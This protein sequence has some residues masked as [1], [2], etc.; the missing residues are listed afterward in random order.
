MAVTFEAL[1][2][3][4][5]QQH[6]TVLGWFGNA[7]ARATQI[8]LIFIDSLLTC[9]LSK[10]RGSKLMCET[11]VERKWNWRFKAQADLAD[12][13]LQLIIYNLWNY[14]IFSRTPWRNSSQIIYLP[15][16]ITLCVIC[17]RWKLKSRSIFTS[18]SVHCV[19]SY[20]IFMNHARN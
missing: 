7:I 20:L 3:L 10:E 4:K 14:L 19:N 6:W 12:C 17:G 15:S 1:L 13:V 5:Q 18:I 9:A 2:H 8:C 16:F 11:V